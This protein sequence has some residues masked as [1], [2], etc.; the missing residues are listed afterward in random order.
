[1][2]EKLLIAQTLSL[3]TTKAIVETLCS[4]A[5][6]TDYAC[7]ANIRQWLTVRQIAKALGVSASTVPRVFGAAGLSSSNST[8]RRRPSAM[9]AIV[10]ANER[11]ERRR[12]TQGEC[13]PGLDGDALAAQW[14]KQLRHCCSCRRHTIFGNSDSISIQRTPAAEPV[15]EVDTEGRD[16]LPD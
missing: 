1:M 5:R 15:A 3:S 14:F 10:P 7:Q 6:S 13:V 8:L 16:L 9:S 12:L 11:L 4:D 2:A